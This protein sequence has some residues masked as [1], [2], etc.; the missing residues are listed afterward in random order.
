MPS[1]LRHNHQHQH[2]HQ[3]QSRQQ[4]GPGCGTV[5]SVSNE[6]SI[7]EKRGRKRLKGGEERRRGRG[8]AGASSP[9]PTHRKM[10]S[11]R[12]LY[13]VGYPLTFLTPPPAKKKGTNK[14]QHRKRLHPHPHRAHLLSGDHPG[15]VELEVERARLG[16]AEVVP[17]GAQ[18]GLAVG[19]GQLPHAGGRLEVDWE[20]LSVLL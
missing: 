6:N 15:V 2:Q 10:S 12:S 7:R 18:H 16:V 14:H 20:P 9:H 19:V 8:G 11:P 17:D 3:H 13:V 1:C 4:H 5:R